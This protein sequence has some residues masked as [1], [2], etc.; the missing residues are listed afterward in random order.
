MVHLDAMQ[1]DTHGHISNLGE[2]PDISHTSFNMH[3]VKYCVQIYNG[4][5]CIVDGLM[6]GKSVIHEECAYSKDRYG[7]AVWIL[8]IITWIHEQPNSATKSNSTTI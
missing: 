8:C 6:N 2:N 3:S 5:M 7:I 4:S 1:G